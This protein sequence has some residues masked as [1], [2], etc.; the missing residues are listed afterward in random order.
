MWEAD[1]EVSVYGSGSRTIQF[2]GGT[3]A[4]NRNIQEFQNGISKMLQDLRF[5]RANYKWYSGADKYD[6]YSIKSPNDGDL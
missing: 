2:V 6:Y 5:T 3:F 1:I 4:A